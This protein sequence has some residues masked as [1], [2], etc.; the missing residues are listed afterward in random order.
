MPGAFAEYIKAYPQMIIP[1]PDGVDS[2]NA[3]LAEVFAAALHG[4]KSSR[5]D[6]GSALVIGGGPI[7]LA[8]ARRTVERLGGKLEWRSTLGRGASFAIELP[9]RR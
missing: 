1:V 3:A 5:K 6:K 7:G 8:L 2:R 4:I 9:G